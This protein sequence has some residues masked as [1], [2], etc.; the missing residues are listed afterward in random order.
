M[1]TEPRCRSFT[2]RSGEL[3]A[4]F[5]QAAGSV[6]GDVA[7]GDAV[8]GGSGFSQFELV[9]SFRVSRRWAV[10]SRTG[11]FFH[12]DGGELPHAAEQHVIVRAG[13]PDQQRAALRID[14]YRGGEGDFH[15]GAFAA[16]LGNFAG[17]ARA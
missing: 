15:G 3:A 14:E 16:R 7:E 4:D 8:F 1:G 10:S 6:E 12:G 13:V 9:A 5:S 17:D 11:A 2:A